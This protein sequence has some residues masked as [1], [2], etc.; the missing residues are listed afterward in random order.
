VLL[1]TC[2]CSCSQNRNVWAERVA[3]MARQ[4]VLQTLAGSPHG[5]PR[6]EAVLVV[7]RLQETVHGTITFDEEHVKVLLSGTNRIKCW[8]FLD[9]SASVTFEIFRMNRNIPSQLS[10]VNSKRLWSLSRCYRGISLEKLKLKETFPLL[11]PVPRVVQSRVKAVTLQKWRL[12][13][14]HSRWINV[15]SFTFL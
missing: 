7:L 9:V 8:E 14:R 13:I 1:F 4:T 5:I 15:K 6:H 11:Q 12:W 3:Y 2:Y 10:S